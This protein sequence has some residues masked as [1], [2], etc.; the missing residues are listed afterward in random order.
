MVAKESVLRTTN[1]I[2]LKCS[3]TVPQFGKVQS[4]AMRNVPKI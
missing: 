3:Q 4:L 1:T 2:F